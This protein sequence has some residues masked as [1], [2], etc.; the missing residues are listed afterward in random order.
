M[1]VVVAYSKGRSGTAW[2]KVQARV[3]AEETHC[4]VCQR[5]VDQELPREHPMSRTVDHVHPLG[6]GGAE[7]DRAN[8]R[9]AH[10]RC[11]TVRSNQLRAR[12]RPRP[13]YAADATSL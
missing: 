3:F 10:R 13:I 4:W 1:E 7:T 5:Y 9:L 6:M 2:F 8:L 12:L 11:N